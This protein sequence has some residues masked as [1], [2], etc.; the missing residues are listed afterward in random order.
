MRPGE[1]KGVDYPE[2]ERIKKVITHLSLVGVL[3][4]TVLKHK[5]EARNIENLLQESINSGLSPREIA[6]PKGTVFAITSCDGEFEFSA[7]SSCGGWDYLEKI[8]FENDGLNDKPTFLAEFIAIDDYEGPDEIIQP[9]VVFAH[10]QYGPMRCKINSSN[11]DISLR[12]MKRSFSLPHEFIVN[13][14]L[15]GPFDSS[16]IA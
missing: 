5:L 6:A 8:K 16:S 2:D 10:S 15:A 12:P 7:P 1:F 3:G 4:E 11:Y 13:R 9:A 14:L